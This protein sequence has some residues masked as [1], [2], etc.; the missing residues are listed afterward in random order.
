MA[1]DT[2]ISVILRLRDEMG[3]RAAKSLDT[4]TRAAHGT[5]QGV[6][7]AAR[8]VGRAGDGVRS[9]GIAAAR[10]DKLMGGMGQAARRTAKEV[11]DVARES[12]QASRE[13]DQT[14][15]AGLRLR[16]ALRGVGTAGHVAM[17]VVKGVG[18]AGAG[19]AA[20]SMVAGRALEKPISYESRLNK[21]ARVAYADKDEAGQIAGMQTLNKVITESTKIGGGTRENAAETLNS[22]FAGGM[23][24]GLASRT[25]PKVLKAS[26][27]GD[28]TANELAKTVLSGLK[29]GYFGEDQI[30]EA[31]DVI[32][33]G[34]Q[35]GS[36]E[37]KDMAKWM[38]ELMAEAKG[39]KNMEG[40]KRL[41]A[42]L[43]GEAVVA[44]SNDKAANNLAN[45]LGK[46][47]SPDTQQDFGKKAGI[48]VQKTLALAAGKGMDPLTAIVKLMETEVFGKNKDFQALKKKIVASKDDKEKSSLLEQMADIVQGSLLG[49]YFQDRQ[50]QLGLVGL[51][52]QK[53]YIANIYSGLNNAHGAVEKGF[54]VASQTTEFKAQ[55]L[56]NEKDNAMSRTFENIGPALNTVIDAATNLAREFPGLATVVAE[57]STAVGAFS[58]G[59]LAAGGFHM[60]TGGGAGAAAVTAG[61]K[62][63]LEKGTTALVGAGTKTAPWLLAGKA[64]WDIYNTETDPSLSRAQ[65]NV[66]NAE[67]YGATATALAGATAGAALGSAIPIIGTA[68]GAF[69]GGLGGWF[70]GGMAGRQTGKWLYEPSP[71]TMEAAKNLVV[72][73][74]RT[75]NFNAQLF[76]DGHEMARVVNK[77]NTAEAKRE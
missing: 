63:L 21:M 29:Q 60:L 16:D 3:G 67:T 37:G 51:M 71:E 70:A 28:I 24:Q 17:G 52:T 74:E 49:K 76:V 61:T 35:L 18:Q 8:E 69:L 30:E 47:T 13:I 10:T 11:G 32:V 77:H 73:D 42:S 59:L 72:K 58:A 19:V 15:K 54:N 34:G 41:V 2:V 31:L 39:M 36:F 23:E 65:K 68:I 7:A 53:D 55:Q 26:T 38:P 64:A 33:K 9:L 46:L 45:L 66:N 27:G 6:G 57:A 50:A 62:G 25:L 1:K 48:D 40:F 14:A 43:Q 44:G 75:I 20:A 5:G 22:L 4:L 56:Q 12:R